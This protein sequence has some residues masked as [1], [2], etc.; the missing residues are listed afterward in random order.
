MQR[1]RSVNMP[2]VKTLIRVPA[3]RE[4][5]AAARM[6]GRYL[7]TLRPEAHSEVGKALTSI[8][9]AAATPIPTGANVAHALPIGHHIVLPRVGVAV[10]DPTPGQQENDL[11]AMADRETNVLALEPERI[12]R[13]I[14]QNTASYV[15]GWRDA[16]DAL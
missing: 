14:I 13:A 3:D 5:R 2:T 1:G 8:G 6:T 11:H 7:M 15:E 12:N 9:I 16:I 4:R 10:I